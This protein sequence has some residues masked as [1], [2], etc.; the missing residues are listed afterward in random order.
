[1]TEAKGNN[2][3]AITNAEVDTANTNGT[4][5]INS[6]QVEIAKKPAANKSIDDTVVA[7]KTL[8]DQ[9]PD[10]TKEEKDVAKTKVDEE[11]NKA[12]QN[13]DRAVTN[14]DVDNETTNGTNAINAVQV[15]VVKKVQARK[16]IDDAVTNK[17]AEIDKNRDATKE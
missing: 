14:N 10:A 7:K 6:I 15:E 5:T 3:H 16:A 11:A 17:K 4:N 2:D 13:I 12:K 9:T 1:M 8:I